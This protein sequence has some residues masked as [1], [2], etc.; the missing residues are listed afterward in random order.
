MCKGPYR[1]GECPGGSSALSVVAE[2]LAILEKVTIGESSCGKFI[3][4]QP[5][6]HEMKAREVATVRGRQSEPLHNFVMLKSSKKEKKS[7]DEEM[8]RV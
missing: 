7:L 8:E 5:M 4:R 2:R 6:K 3:R 1:V